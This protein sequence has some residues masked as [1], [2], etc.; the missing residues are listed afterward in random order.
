MLVGTGKLFVVAALGLVFMLPA[1]GR[2]QDLGS[3][4]GMIRTNTTG[5]K[6]STSKK[7]YQ[8]GSE[9]EVLPGKERTGEKRDGQFEI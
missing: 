9:G 5:T 8:T 2:A 1:L 4:G 6:S 7:N 3:I